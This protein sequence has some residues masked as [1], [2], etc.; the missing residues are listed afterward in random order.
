MTAPERTGAAGADRSA[1]LPT[2]I[3]VPAFLLLGSLL[4][5][6]DFWKPDLWIDEYGTWW[7]VAEG[8]WGEVIRRVLHIHGQS[9]LYYFIVKL[10]TDLLGP[11]PFSLRLPSILFGIGMLALAYPLGHT[12]FHDRHAALLALAAFSVKDNIIWYS[13]DARPYA[14]ALLLT[15]LSFLCYLGLLRRE[16][17]SLRIGYVLATGAMFYAHYLFG[18]VL[19]IQILYLFF[20]R[21]WSWLRS[22]PWPGTFLALTLFCLPGLVQLRRIFGRRETLDWVDPPGDILAPLR[23]ALE[24]LDPLVFAS[25]TLTLLA[26]GMRAHEPPSG[27]DRTPLLLLWLLVPIGVFAV[28]P[29]LMGVRLLHIRYV[30]FVIPAAIL[31]TVKMMGLAKRSGL[32]EWAPLAVFLTL[33]FVANL[34]PLYQARGVFSAHGREGWKL[35]GNLLEKQAQPNDLI[36]YRSGFVE[37]RQIGTGSLDPVVVSW[38]NWPLTANFPS[39]QKYQMLTLPYIWTQESLPLMPTFLEEAGKHR[40]VWLVGLGE[41]IPKM[42]EAVLGNPAFHQKQFLKF[43]NVTVILLEQGSRPLPGLIFP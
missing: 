30:L 2:F 13:Q 21:G 35:A 18:F 31:I 10:F 32:R 41:I 1:W 37:A 4:R 11:S 5:L 38:M 36:L 34:F 24:M 27:A 6:Y 42:A 19:V 26:V 14:L 39:V 25:V 7:A 9:P 16:R 15:M 3:L 29:P 23:F 33:S 12:I 40:R 17:T 20:V 8:D 43:G 28:V 22:R